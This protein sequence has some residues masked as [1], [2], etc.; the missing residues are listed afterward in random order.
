MPTA[1]F[2][3]SRLFGPLGMTTATIEADEHG[4]LVESSYRYARAIGLA[5]RSSCCKRVDDLTNACCRQH[6]PS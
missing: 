6:M 2:V 3:A 1:D 5:M 4:T